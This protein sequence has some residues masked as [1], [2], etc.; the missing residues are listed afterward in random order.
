MT[1]LTILRKILI[2]SVIAGLGGLLYAFC[3]NLFIKSG[4]MPV[5]AVDTAFG[6]QMTE[7]TVFVWLASLIPAAMC[8]FFAAGKWRWLIITAPLY[9]PSVFA[10]IYILTNSNS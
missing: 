1:I 6:Y 9:A 4:M 7:K 8:M 5:D 10:V 2:L 3:A